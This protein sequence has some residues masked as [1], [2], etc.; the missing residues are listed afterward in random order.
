MGPRPHVAIKSNYRKTALSPAA[1]WPLKVFLGNVPARTP[2]NPAI[3]QC[4]RRASTQYR[5]S[6]TCS[7]KGNAAV[8]LVALRAQW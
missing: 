2:T 1:V 6:I 4:D 7:T 5:A 8:C 3:V